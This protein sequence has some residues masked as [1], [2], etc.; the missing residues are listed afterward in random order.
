MRPFLLIMVV[1]I[2]LDFSPHS[3]QVDIAGT[4]FLSNRAFRVIFNQF[5]ACLTQVIEQFSLSCIPNHALC[6]RYSHQAGAF[7]DRLYLMQAAGRI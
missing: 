4:D 3:D 7:A 6:P 2:E 5:I 1:L